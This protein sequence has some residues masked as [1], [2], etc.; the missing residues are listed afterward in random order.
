[1][2]IPGG[3]A[4]PRREYRHANGHPIPQGEA[5]PGK[6]ALVDRLGAK[7]ETATSSQIWGFYELSVRTREGK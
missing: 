1:V 2:A 5:V 7:T 4:G 3:L 6:L